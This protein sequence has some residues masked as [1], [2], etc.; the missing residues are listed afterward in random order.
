MAQDI[1]KQQ[2]PTSPDRATPSNG[3]KATAAGAAASPRGGNAAVVSVAA[4]APPSPPPT[5]QQLKFSIDRILSPEF[6]PRANGR[7]QG[8]ARKEA[9]AAARR[10]AAAAAA[11]ATDSSGDDARSVGKADLP[12][13]GAK[14]PG[15]PG[16]LWPAWVYCTRY[17]DRPSS[18]GVRRSS[19]L[20]LLWPVSLPDTRVRAGP[21][22]EVDAARWRGVYKS[23][24]FVL[25][26][27]SNREH[28]LMG[29]SLSPES[30]PL[31]PLSAA[32]PPTSFLSERRLSPS[33]A[34]ACISAICAR[35]PRESNDGAAAVVGPRKDDHDDGF[36][37]RGG[38][39]RQ[40]RPG[41]VPASE[42]STRAR[43][44]RTL[45]QK[46]NHTPIALL[47]GKR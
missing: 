1:D 22:S 7:H 19:G 20:L 16:L 47:R 15:T 41:P 27:K 36:P 13:N 23:P 40:R 38:L 46:P 25:Q 30:S 29:L 35:P 21:L 33:G 14:A 39:A 32:P 10:E 12:V 8:R 24:R 37:L 43:G 42:S 26:I 17:S 3:L 2:Q 6:G 45:R 5:Q 34:A 4:P 31:V 18:A 44:G 9:A 28:C 11:A